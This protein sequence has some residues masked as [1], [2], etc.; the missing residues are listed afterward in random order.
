MINL[1]LRVFNSFERGD[2]VYTVEEE[3]LTLAVDLV[4]KKKNY[5]DIDIFVV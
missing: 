4:L 3:Q 2:L 1:F 5:I